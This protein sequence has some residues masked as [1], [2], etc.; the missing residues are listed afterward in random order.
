MGVNY[1]LFSLPLSDLRAYLTIRIG[2]F[3]IGLG[4]VISDYVLSFM[5]R[6]ES[7]ISISFFSFNA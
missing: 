1:P 4:R 2:L 3:L 6:T 5:H 7:F